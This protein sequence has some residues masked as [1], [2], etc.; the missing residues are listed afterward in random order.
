LAHRSTA[1]ATLIRH[2]HGQ[3]CALTTAAIA[4]APTV[5]RLSAVQ[6][7]GLLLDRTRT[8]ASRVP[9][10]NVQHAAIR[11]RLRSGVSCKGTIVW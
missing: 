10:I 5:G 7:P 2:C 8:A 9:R 1:T 3:M 4:T 11:H 6:P